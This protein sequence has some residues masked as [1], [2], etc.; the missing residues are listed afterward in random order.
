MPNFKPPTKMQS[1]SFYI[2]NSKP[3]TELVGS[4]SEY[5]SQEKKRN[6]E[7]EDISLNLPIKSKTHGF[8][9]SKALKY[10]HSTFVIQSQDV[11]KKLFKNNLLSYGMP[12][13]EKTK[14]KLVNLH[15]PFSINIIKLPTV[16]D[17]QIFNYILTNNITEKKYIQYSSFKNDKFPLF[18]FDNRSE[19]PNVEVVGN[20][21]KADVTS[22]SKINGKPHKNKVYLR[23]LNKMKYKTVSN[24]KNV[25]DQTFLIS[26]DRSLICSKVGITNAISLFIRDFHKGEVS[27]KDYDYSTSVVPSVQEIIPNP[28]S[29]EDALEQCEPPKYRENN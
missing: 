9:L 8:Q 29:Y 12:I 3:N 5:P 19:L 2:V 18:I 20:M 25:Y 23:I 4:C 1:S 14:E 21:I 24:S 28:P 13:T 27:S 22:I 11:K 17:E 7:K 10:N 16:T 6:S 26:P 15:F